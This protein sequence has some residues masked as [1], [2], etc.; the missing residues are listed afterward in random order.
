MIGFGTFSTKKN[1]SI[2]ARMQLG[3]GSLQGCAIP[4]LYM[5]NIAFFLK[6]ARVLSNADGIGKGQIF[7]ATPILKKIKFANSFERETD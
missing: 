4:K 6:K 3:I 7:C 5:H 2:I 1:L